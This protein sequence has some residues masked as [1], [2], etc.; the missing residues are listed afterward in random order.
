MMKTA[1]TTLS[2]ILL[3][4]IVAGCGPARRITALHEEVEAEYNAGNYRIALE[5]Y[6]EII[7]LEKSRNRE[8]DGET[9]YRA[10]ISAWE[11][12]HRNKAIEY[13]VQAGRKDTSGERGYYILATAYRE[14]DNLSL[15]ITNLENYIDNYPGGDKADE[16]RIRLFDTYLESNNTDRALELWEDLEELAPGNAGLLESW[17]ELNRHLGRDGKLKDIARDLY[18][19]DNTNLTALEYLGDHYFWLAENRYQEE[20]TAYEQNQT[21][22]QYRQLLN[23]LETINEN[24]RISRRYF[25]KLWEIDPRPS[26]A[27][28]LRN[29]YLRFGNEERAEYYHRRSLEP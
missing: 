24:F 29:I 15:E 14:I 9:W 10:G 7:E 21:R 5:L 1:Q 20:F 17:Y 8:A 19:A 22:A 13:L 27:E 12:G 16:M 25:E 28:Y 26:Y 6:E 18:N 2:V 3:L 4:A 11:T 23:A